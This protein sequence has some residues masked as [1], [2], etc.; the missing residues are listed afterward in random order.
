MAI[1]HHREFTTHALTLG[2][3]AAGIAR[4]RYLLWETTTTEAQT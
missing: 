4:E 2:L 3:H 1:S